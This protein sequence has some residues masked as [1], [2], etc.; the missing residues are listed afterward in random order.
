MTLIC[1]MLMGF[2]NLMIVPMH[3]ETLVSPGCGIAM[4]VGSFKRNLAQLS[5]SLRRVNLRFWD[6]T[7]GA[8]H[9]GAP[10][11]INQR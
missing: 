3:V 8:N 6:S 1:R 10:Y 5:L 4:S 7:C 11:S 9:C 2:S